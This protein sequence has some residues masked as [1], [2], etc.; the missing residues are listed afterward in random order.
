VVSPEAEAALAQMEEADRQG[1]L[2]IWP[3][4]ADSVAI[5]FGMGTQWRWV[6]VGLAGAVRTGLDYSALPSIAAAHSIEVTP[7]ILADLRTMENAAVK[8]WGRKR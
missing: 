6:G 7:R 4:M 8:Q 2:E 3:D 1:A 5:F